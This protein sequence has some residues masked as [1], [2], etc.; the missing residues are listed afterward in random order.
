MKTTFINNDTGIKIILTPESEIERL[1]LKKLSTV[2]TT[3]VESL[4]IMNTPMPDSLIIE[5]VEPK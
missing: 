4:Q 2:K 3:Q 1:A 5:P